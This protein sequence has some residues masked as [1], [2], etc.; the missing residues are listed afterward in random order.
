MKTT[1]TSAF[2][3]QVVLELLKEEKTISQLAAEYKVHLNV[4]RDWR[5]LA[6]KNLSTL[7]H[8]RHA[9][10]SV[11]SCESIMNGGCTRHWAI[12][13]LQKSISPQGHR[14][15]HLILGSVKRF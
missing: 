10:N 13:R 15:T 1:Y 9:Y 4:L 5:M 8:A 11:S 12:V 2:K 7:F 3:A 14:I 6:V